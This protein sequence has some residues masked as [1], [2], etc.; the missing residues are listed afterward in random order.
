M[1]IRNGILWAGLL[2]GIWAGA[3][4]PLEIAGIRP[5]LAVFN[6]DGECGI[7][8]V[9]PW[10]GRLWWITYP[11]HRRTG[12]G[13][14]LYSTDESFRLVRHPESV[15]GTHE[16]RMIH[17]E[18]RQLLIGPYAIDE[19]G[20]VRAM[21]VKAIPGRYTAWARHLTEPARK[22]LLPDMEGP[23]W[24][25]DLATLTGRRLSEKPVPG[26][27]GKGAYTGQGRFVVA[28]NGELAAGRTLTS[29]D[30]DL[31]PP[32]P[33]DAGVLA[34]WDGQR[35]TVLLRRKFTDITGPGG[36]HGAPDDRAPVWA[37][38]WDARSVL[39]MLLDGGRWH[40][41]RLPKGSFT[42]DPR[43]GWFTEWPRI[44]EIDG[45]RMLMVMHGLIWDFPREFSAAATAGLRPIATHLRIIPDFC[46]WNGRLV[47]ASDDCSIMQNP[48]ASKSQS[49]LWIGR[50][51]DLPTFGSPIGWGSVWLGDR[52]EAGAVSDPFL[53]AG[54]ERRCVHI[55]HNA[56]TPVEV[57][58]ETDLDGRGGWA[59][60]TNLAV[61][62]QGYAVAVLPPD[63]GGDWVRARVDRG[64]SALSVTFHLA[65]ARHH[66]VGGDAALFE[67]LA[68][69][70]TAGAGT[71]WTHAIL[72][73]GAGPLH[74]RSVEILAD[75]STGRVAHLD[76]D[77][78]LRFAETSDASIRARMDGAQAVQP[79]WSADAA[80]V[81][82][83]DASGRTWRLPRAA[84]GADRLGSGILRGGREV[85]TER[86][87]AQFAGLF[88]EG[89]AHRW[90]GGAGLPPDETGGGARVRDLRLLHLARLAR[91]GRPSRWR[92]GGRPGG[93]RSGRTLRPLAGPD[94]RTLEAGQA[95]R[96]RR[97]MEGHGRPRRT[98]VRP[99]P[100][101]RLRSEEPAPRRPAARPIP[102][103]GGLFQ[104]RF[105]EGLRR[106][107]G[108]IRRGIRARVSGGFSAHWVRV[109]ADAD[110]AA[111]AQFEYR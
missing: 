87:L 74:V 9:V 11:P 65:A 110:C 22:A 14:G 58:F 38:G 54:F 45:G 100:D 33:E 81:V 97:A 91:A 67:G 41:F 103:R 94:R 96:R 52:V 78:S 35:W 2:V 90:P 55:A 40:R 3:S 93:G 27:H 77:E 30:C 56:G 92:V 34:E 83:R 86:F 105:L 7:G 98:A 61:G 69:A 76:V 70:A 44:R 42:Y 109:T 79:D 47:L 19:H 73:P 84:P 39:L 64:A 24:E 95:G 12:S 25:I 59:P 82:V 20:R 6:D 49:N 50:A 15:G 106:I 18:T 71:A 46:E 57:R 31:P 107:R 37:V 111:T 8:A 17:R 29:F 104:P 102:R 16:A 108:G 10:S 63:A 36:I 60:L 26:W 80:S 88:Y 68:P 66:P 101:D 32:S 5:S 62:A 85:V 1:T 23:V 28:N 13:D 51:E 53:W 89:P 21:D 72:R 99:V 75:G 43:H 4:E 48:L